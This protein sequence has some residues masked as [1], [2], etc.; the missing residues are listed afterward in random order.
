[1]NSVLLLASF[2]G[3]VFWKNN[4]YCLFFQNLFSF[5]TLESDSKPKKFI[6]TALYKLPLS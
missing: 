4:L 1:M 6:E 5:Y 2:H 3:Q